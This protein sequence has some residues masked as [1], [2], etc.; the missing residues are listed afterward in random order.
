MSKNDITKHQF[1]KGESGNKNGRPKGT[2]S[3]KNQLLKLIKDLAQISDKI[4][5]RE[6]ML[7]YQLYEI[8]EGDINN[9]NSI[10]SSIN[11]LYFMES[12][13]GIKIGISKDVNNRLKQIKVYAPSAKIIKI[14]EYA[15]KFESNIHK[16]FESI[17]IKNNPIIGIEWFFK[18]DDLMSFI[19]DVQNIND[20]HK[21]FNPKGSGQL[22]LF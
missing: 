11:H 20:M 22:K 17:N 6:K 16:K 19:E 1:K 14:I 9:S 10:S 12:E 2:V 13:F 3:K 21:Y 15:G 5:E 18:T 7:V 8:V 4:T